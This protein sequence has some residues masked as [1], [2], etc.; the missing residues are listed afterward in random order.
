MS[1]KLNE[2]QHYHN[3]GIKEK[4]EKDNDWRAGLDCNK[5]KKICLK[6]GLQMCDH[7]DECNTGFCNRQGT[8]LK[9]CVTKLGVIANKIDNA[10]KNILNPHSGKR[11]RY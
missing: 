7:D 8:I 10:R 5:E 2:P 3:K 6:E 4:C 1:R 9:T 11:R